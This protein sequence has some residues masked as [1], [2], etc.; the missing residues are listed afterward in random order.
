MCVQDRVEILTIA[1]MNLFLLS[2]PIVVYGN[3]VTVK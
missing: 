3:G 1:V 2:S